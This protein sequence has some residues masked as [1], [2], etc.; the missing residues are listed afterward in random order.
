[1]TTVDPLLAL[2]P[3]KIS[4]PHTSG[5][6]EQNKWWGVAKAVLW[7]LVTMVLG[8]ALV[9]VVWQLFLEIFG[10][11]PFIGRGPAD[12]WDFLTTGQVGADARDQLWTASVTTLTDAGLGLFAGASVAVLVALFFNLSLIHI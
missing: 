7:R 4:A 6:P 8:I 12:V 1:M 3:E 9:L 10:V 5:A 2:E 11:D